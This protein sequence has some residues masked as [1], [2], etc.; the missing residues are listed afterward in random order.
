MLALQHAQ[1]WLHAVEAGTLRACGADQAAASRAE[2]QCQLNL[3]LYLQ[4]SRGVWSW[5]TKCATP[6]RSCTRRSMPTSCATSSLSLSSCCRRCPRRP[7]APLVSDTW[8]RLPAAVWVPWQ[9][10]SSPSEQDSMLCCDLKH[11]GWGT[12][13]D[14]MAQ[15]RLPRKVHV[16]STSG[17]IEAPCRPGMLQNQLEYRLCFTSFKATQQEESLQISTDSG[18]FGLCGC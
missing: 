15:A 1:T 2:G 9:T 5:P 17:C 7:A 18:C 6:S 14:I 11:P 16:P 8:T 12:F 10:S 3:I 4:G 13:A